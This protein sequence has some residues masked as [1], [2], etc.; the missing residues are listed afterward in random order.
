M[1]EELI[2][3]QYEAE[4]YKFA[5]LNKI[6]S[7]DAENKFLELNNFKPPK[8]A[9]NKA[10]ILEEFS[11]K[12]EIQ[13]GAMLL[14]NDNKAGKT[15]SVTSSVLTLAFYILYLLGH[16]VNPNFKGYTFIPI[17]LTLVI[18][19]VFSK[20]IKK[21]TENPVEIANKE[22]EDFRKSVKDVSK[23][24]F[25]KY[26][27]GNID[28]NPGLFKA[29]IKNTEKKRINSYPLLRVV[30][31]I[32]KITSIF[33]YLVIFLPFFKN[34]RDDVFSVVIFINMISFIINLV[35][36]VIVSRNY[37]RIISSIKEGA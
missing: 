35:V 23:Q 10:K 18:V 9:K 16:F 13:E 24:S 33:I 3:K 20:K 12:K 15:L 30:N 22:F 21:T 19:L 1:N 36:D 31:F 32:R 27:K 8:N 26:V 29:I 4:V 7:Q 37:K 5:F 34:I 25:V 17:I 6:K 28:K 14:N 2:N 11:I